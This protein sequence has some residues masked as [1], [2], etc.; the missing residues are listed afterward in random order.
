VLF[1]FLQKNLIRPN[2]IDERCWDGN[3][4]RLIKTTTGSILSDREFWDL[5]NG[6]KVIASTNDGQCTLFVS[7]SG[8]GKNIELVSKYLEAMKV[9]HNLISTIDSYAIVVPIESKF[10]AINELEK[11]RW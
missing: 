1:L 11:W 4:A 3:M 5:D 7:G 10:D 6:F 2:A 8:N 9:K